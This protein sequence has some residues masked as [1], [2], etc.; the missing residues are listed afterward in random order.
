MLVTLR[1]HSLYVCVPCSL[2]TALHHSRS[3][4]LLTI[5][6]ERGDH[7]VVPGRVC[8][9]YWGSGNPNAHTLTGGGAQSV[10][11]R[12]LSECIHFINRPDPVVHYGSVFGG[13]I[14]YVA[15]APNN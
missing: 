11:F 3:S 2:F 10:I 1:G 15:L 8:L 12:Y 13:S 5:L 9:G 7:R 6:V 4:P 14:L